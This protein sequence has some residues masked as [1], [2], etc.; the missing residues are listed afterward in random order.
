MRTTLCWMFRVFPIV[1]WAESPST[2]GR[3]RDSA[4]A[5]SRRVT[6]R[7]KVGPIREYMRLRRSNGGP[8]IH[9]M[10]P[11]KR[12][13][14]S[15]PRVFPPI[16]MVRQLHVACVTRQILPGSVGTQRSATQFIV[17]VCF[18]P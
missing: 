2:S 4:T 11:G 17:P 1:F 6:V 7:H 9:L 13:S 15:A 18:R 16:I 10:A 14:T 12:F 3:T 8:D 5:G